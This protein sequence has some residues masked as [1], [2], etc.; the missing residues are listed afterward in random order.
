MTTAT[1]ASSGPGELELTRGCN[2]K[3]ATAS[4]EGNSAEVRDD[5]EGGSEDPHT[6]SS[7]SQGAQ[8]ER[9]APNL[10][11][12]TREMVVVRGQEGC[13]SCHLS[14]YPVSVEP[15]IPI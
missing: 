12:L 2:G 1:K 3:L 5:G 15:T 9:K 13:V 4:R 6:A 14:K 7:G 10:P 8:G 11:E